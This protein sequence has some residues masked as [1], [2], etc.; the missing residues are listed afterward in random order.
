[1]LALSVLDIAFQSMVK[2]KTINLVF[3]ASALSAQHNGKDWLAGNQDNM[4]ELSNMPTC[5]WTVVSVS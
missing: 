1:M 5:V 2:L 3:V 4:S